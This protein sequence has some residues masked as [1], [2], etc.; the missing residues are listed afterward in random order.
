MADTAEVRDRVLLAPKRFRQFREKSIRQPGQLE[1]TADRPFR[2]EG[3]AGVHD[4]LEELFRRGRKH[5]A[6]LGCLARDHRT[7]WWRGSAANDD[8]SLFEQEKGLLA[9]VR[10]P[11]EGARRE[12]QDRAG[13][14]QL[15]G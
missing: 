12:R 13:C 7:G 6:A 8:E 3:E 5:D 11:M 9:C 15:G 1:E 14:E 2:Q 4:R 10:G